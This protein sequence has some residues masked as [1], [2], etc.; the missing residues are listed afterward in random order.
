MAYLK[1]RKI[2]VD[3]NDKALSS[4]M[5]FVDRSSY[6]RIGVIVES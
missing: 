6:A 2:V 4:V 5:Q 3:V 1:A